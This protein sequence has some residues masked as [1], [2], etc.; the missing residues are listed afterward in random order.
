MKAKVSVDRELLKR[1]RAQTKIR[2]GDEVVAHA[3][4]TL[5]AVQAGKKLARLGGSDPRASSAPRVRTRR[6]QSRRGRSAA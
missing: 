1:A 5:L 2:D 3:L 6:A 4:R